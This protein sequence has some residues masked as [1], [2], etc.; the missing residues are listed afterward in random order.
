MAH[1]V[2]WDGSRPYRVRYSSAIRATSGV[3]C[4]R[5]ELNVSMT[6]WSTPPISNPF[7]SGRGTST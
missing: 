4:A 6:P 1:S 5:R 7:P 3:I 2:R